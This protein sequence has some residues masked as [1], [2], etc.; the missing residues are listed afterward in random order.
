PPPPPPPRPGGGPPPCWRA[1]SIAAPRV[2]VRP[3]VSVT[4][5]LVLETPRAVLRPMP[6]GRSLVSPSRLASRPVVIVYGDADCARRL[7]S[8]RNP[9]H[10]LLL[11]DP[12]S[13]CRL[14]RRD[15]PP[16]PNRSKLS[17]GRLSAPSLSSK[18][19]PSVYATV[20]DSRAG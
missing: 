15:G 18:A 5:R 16:P 12:C 8:K 13:R 1:G 3:Q 11:T 17:G 2:R 14:S 4:S 19:S 20:L 6:A 9:A 10:R 7:A